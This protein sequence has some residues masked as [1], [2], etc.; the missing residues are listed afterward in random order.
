MT[1][2]YPTFERNMQPVTVTACYLAQDSDEEILVNVEDVLTPH[3]DDEVDELLED[4]QGG[5]GVNLLLGSFNEMLLNSC[6]EA[7][8]WAAEGEDAVLET[9][10]HTPSILRGASGLHGVVDS[11]AGSTTAS[12]GGYC[13]PIRTASTMAGSQGGQRPLSGL[14]KNYTR[15]PS[16]HVLRLPSGQCVPMSPLLN[17]MI[18][19]QRNTS[20]ATLPVW[21]GVIV[22]LRHQQSAVFDQHTPG[23]EP[24]STCTSASKSDVA[25][26]FGCCR[27]LVL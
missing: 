1:H 27:Q 13:P 23:Y 7:E 5:I 18:H 4:P 19:H 21:E 17:K 6:P 11:A 9:F 15:P 2:A 10:G 14:M 22:P 20:E 8:A 25:G 12:Q 24:L 3:P 26:R 16:N